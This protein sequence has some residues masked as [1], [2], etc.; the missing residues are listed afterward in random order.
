MVRATLAKYGVKK[1]KIA[2]PYHRQ[3]SGQVEISNVNA[4]RK[5]WSRKLDDA[6]W[7]YQTAFKTPISMSPYKLFYGKACHLPIELEHKALWALKHLNLNWDETTNMRLGQLN[8][9]DEFYLGAYERTD[10][11][12]EQIKK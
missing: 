2:M 7:S 11:N 9:M 3:T 5:D 10:L 6:L 4:R 12:K 1:H 8:R